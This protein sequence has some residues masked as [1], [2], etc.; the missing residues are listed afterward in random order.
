MKK[1]ILLAVL[2]CTPA[3]AADIVQD[4]DYRVKVSET[5]N[6]IEYKDAI[7]YT[8]SEWESIKQA[9]VTAEIQ[10]RTDSFRNAIENPA[11]P[12]EP[13]KEML[14]AEKAEY[15]ARIAELDTQIAAKGK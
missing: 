10:K 12:V 15:Q 13:T 9:D 7:Y 4:Y 8:P 2:I 6:G 1:I 3:F 14:E 11:E 5:V